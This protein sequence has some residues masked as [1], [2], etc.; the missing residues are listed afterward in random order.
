MSRCVKA[1]ES[2]CEYASQK[3]VYLG[4]ENHGGVTAK[5]E[6][7]LEIVRKVQAKSFGINFD[8]GNFRSTNDPYKELEQIAPYAV[9][10]QIKVEIFVNGN[11]EETDLKRVMNILRTAGYSGWVALEYE[12]KEDPLTAI[13]IWL[14]KLRQCF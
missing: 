12:A 7:L 11:K 14:N 1:C 3:G 2:V 5:A 6:G 4:L 8:C 9:N 13:P 10:A